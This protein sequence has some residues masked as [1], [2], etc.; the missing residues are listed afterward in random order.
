MRVE[1]NSEPSLEPILSYLCDPA[2]QKRQV[3]HDETLTLRVSGTSCTLQLMDSLPAREELYKDFSDRCQ[4]IVNEAMKWA[5]KS[6]RSHLLE[7][8]N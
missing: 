5:P 8:P 6:T 7:Y 1:N 3:W 2:L 4:G